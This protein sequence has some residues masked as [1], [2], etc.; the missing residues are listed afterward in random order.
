[1]LLGI[2]C[3]G[4][5]SLAV[6]QRNVWSYGKILSSDKRKRNNRTHQVNEMLLE[7]K[8]S[9]IENI[10]PR[11]NEGFKAVKNTIKLDINNGITEGYVNKLKT[12]KRYMYGKAGIEL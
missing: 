4:A 11:Y 7:N 6:V 12:I 3:Q 1:M 5:C 10:Y 2:L 9:I 8:H